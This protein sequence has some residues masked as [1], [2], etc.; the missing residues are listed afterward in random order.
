MEKQILTEIRRIREM[1]NLSLLKEQKDELYNLLIKLGREGKDE[2]E[3]IEIR[4]A[5]KK[6]G[7]SDVEIRTIAAGGEDILNNAVRRLEQKVAGQGLGDL[8]QILIKQG[9]SKDA[10]A[11]LPDGAYFI[12][13]VEGLYTRKKNGLISDAQYQQK[14][15]DVI[16]ALSDVANEA[17]LKRAIKSIELDIDK[18]ID[19]KIVSE[20]IPMDR[21]LNRDEIITNPELNSTLEEIVG[22]DIAK[23]ARKEFKGM[24]DSQLKILYDELKRGLIRDENLK[25]RASEAFIKKPSLWKSF[26]PWQKAVASVAGGFGVLYALAYIKNTSLD[27]FIEDTKSIWKFVDELTLRGEEKE[28]IKT[29]EELSDYVQ[30]VSNYGVYDKKDDKFVVD[31]ETFIGSEGTVENLLKDTVPNAIKGYYDLNKDNLNNLLIYEFMSKIATGKIQPLIDNVEELKDKFT[32]KGLEYNDDNR[33]K[34]VGR[35]L[36]DLVSQFREK[37]DSKY[38]GT[39]KSNPEAEK[40]QKTSYEQ[41]KQNN[42]PPNFPK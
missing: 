17:E 32:V 40:R 18:Q 12:D 28:A 15:N 27:Q 29:K 20:P 23:K 38:K 10:I 5:L 19:K 8:E 21:P 6:Q 11:S 35:N 1:M 16:N 42:L 33:P 36:S 30:K 41:P 13:G 3:K 7:F 22:I 34:T 26:N 9:I 25:I 2:A 37:F 24:S 14:L 39:L 4:N 31:L